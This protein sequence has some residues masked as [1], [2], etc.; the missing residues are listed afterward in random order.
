[1]ILE[2]PLYRQIRRRVSK[3]LPPVHITL[4]PVAV[5]NH[6]ASNWVLHKE[7]FYP[8]TE[9]SAVLRPL[10]QTLIENDTHADIATL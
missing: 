3:I 4:D 7:G 1:L 10:N 8:I 2:L 5:S 6:L 9:F